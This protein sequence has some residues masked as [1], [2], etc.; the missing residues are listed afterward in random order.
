MPEGSSELSL[1]ATSQPPHPPASLQIHQPAFP[2]P[3]PQGTAVT[4]SHLQLQPGDVE[5][6][7]GE[8][9]LHTSSIPHVLDFHKKQW[10]CFPFS[11]H[12]MPKTKFVMEL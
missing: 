4:P 11:F 8:L 2:A 7:E 9:H 3:A 10:L 1:G 5:Q 12:Y 6:K